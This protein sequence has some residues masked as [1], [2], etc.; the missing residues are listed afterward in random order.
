[1]KFHWEHNPNTHEDYIVDCPWGVYYKLQAIPDDAGNCSGGKNNWYGRTCG[2]PWGGQRRGQYWCRIVYSDGHEEWLCNGTSR[3]RPYHAYLEH[4]ESVLLGDASAS[5]GSLSAPIGENIGD[6]D[7]GVSEFQSNISEPMYAD[8]GEPPA[9]T[10]EPHRDAVADLRPGDSRGAVAMIP[11]GTPFDDEL[12][13]RIRLAVDAGDE[14]ATLSTLKLNEIV[15]VDRD[16]ID[17]STERSRRLGTGPQRVPAWMLMRAWEYLSS[18][19]S[20]SQQGLLDDLDVKR[21]A[22]VCALLATFPDVDVE[23]LRPTVLT[24]API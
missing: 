16:G 24:W 9:R 1:V 15:S 21:S 14:I 11:K 13:E 22:F 4:K 17:V 5:G 6:H 12:F 10:G 8:L 2:R 19:G 7:S 20:L 23:S 18:H 3:A